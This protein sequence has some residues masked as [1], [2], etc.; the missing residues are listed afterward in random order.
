MNTLT[1]PLVKAFVY[2]LFVYSGMIKWLPFSID[3]T[4]VLAFLASI[5]ITVSSLSGITVKNKY[6]LIILVFLITF[7]LYCIISSAY[8]PSQIFWK[9]KA[10]SII[11]SIITF[12][13][14]VICFK[15]EKDFEKVDYSFRFLTTTAAII[16]FLLLI[17]GNLSFITGSRI[18]VESSFIPDYLAVGELLGIG[19]IIYLYQSGTIRILL[20]I[21]IFAMLVILGARGPFLFTIIAITIYFSLKK[22]QRLFNF[23]SLFILV[24]LGALFIFLAQLWSGAELLRDRLLSFSDFSEEES[25]LERLVAFQFGLNAFVENPFWGLGLGGFGLYGYG[26]DENVYPHNIF[27]EIVAELGIVGLVL[28]STSLIYLIILARKQISH[29]HIQIYFTLFLFILLNYFKSG[30]LI[31]ARKLFI[32]IGILVAYANFIINNRQI[33]LFNATVVL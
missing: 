1:S 31:D 2:I 32:M 30:G 7:F 9:Q 23:N 14:P 33:Q 12:V 21:F 10:L 24:V 25:T 17:T 26:V 22:N 28:F 3:P 6:V 8:S 29:P 4:L 15:T 19:V 18:G 27:I 13:F 5:I 20:A 16:V 11:L